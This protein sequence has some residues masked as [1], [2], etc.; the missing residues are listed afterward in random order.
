MNEID[1]EENDQAEV[2]G[3]VPV[4][5]PAINPFMKPMTEE[6]RSQVNKIIVASE[7]MTEK[8]IQ[9]WNHRDKLRQVIADM[10]CPWHRGQIIQLNN[11]QGPMDRRV[12]VGAVGGCTEEG[13]F[14][15]VRTRVLAKGMKPGKREVA[16]VIQAD[17]QIEVIGMFDGEL[18]VV[19]QVRRKMEI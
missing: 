15:R 10:T 2:G 18:P 3:D 14:Y 12:I 9:G 4:T 11:G 8:L 1:Y 6:Y 13:E 7:S 19:N 16:L 17:L 5:T